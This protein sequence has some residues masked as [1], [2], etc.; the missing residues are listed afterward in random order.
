MK[1]CRNGWKEK[2][3][4]IYTDENDF[5]QCPYCGAMMVWTMP[6]K[7]F[8]E[9]N[10]KV[11]FGSNYF[12]ET[13]KEVLELINELKNTH[14]VINI[15][16]SEI[17]DW[18]D[19]PNEWYSATVIFEVTDK[20]KID[21]LFLEMHRYRPNEFDNVSGWISHARRPGIYRMWWD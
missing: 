20:T 1:H 13:T 12:G 15:M 17:M 8:F 6:Y 19:L 10:E 16:V 9:G 21:K 11:E 7:Q 2:C 5:E 4:K 3:L 18:D 14:H